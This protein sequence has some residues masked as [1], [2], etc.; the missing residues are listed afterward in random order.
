MV[1]AHDPLNMSGRTVIVT[2]GSK[3]LG[4][5]IAMRF[6]EQGADVVICARSEPDKPVAVAG[7]TALF[8]AADVRD[9]THIADV[10]SAAVATTGRLDV[11]VNNAG[12]APPSAS[13]TVSPRFNDKIIALNLVAPLNFARA[14]HDQ[15]QSQPDGGVIVNIGSVGGTRANPAGAAYGAAKAGLVNL[16]ETLAHEWGPKIRVVALVVGMIVTEQAHLYYGDEEG[17]AAVGHTLALK[18]MGTP[19]EVADVVLFAASPL[20]R[21]VSGCAIPVHGGGER[22]GYIDASTTER[23]AQRQP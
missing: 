18:R 17:I 2:G 12:G 10:V 21:W 14:V 5:V 8:V 4:R 1:E 7:R 23:L 3:G 13:A 20:A 11:L 16:T 19:A 15:M 6:L 22:P 9:R